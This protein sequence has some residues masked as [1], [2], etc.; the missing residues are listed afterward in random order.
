ML[1]MEFKS[2]LK[3]LNRK[4]KVIGKKEVFLLFIFID[5]LKLLNFIKI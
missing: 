2:V 4:V 1:I 5:K 3:L